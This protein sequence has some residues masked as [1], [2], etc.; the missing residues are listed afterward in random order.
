MARFY[1]VKGRCADVRIRYHYI[2]RGITRSRAEG[3]AVCQRLLVSSLIERIDDESN[4]KTAAA[5]TFTDNYT[6]YRFTCDKV[7]G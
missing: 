6:F 2:F 5:A 7:S 3:V 1:D 4:T